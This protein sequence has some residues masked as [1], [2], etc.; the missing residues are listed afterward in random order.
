RISIPSCRKRICYDDLLDSGG[1]LY[2]SSNASHQVG[3]G[4]FV[5]NDKN[6]VL[7]VQEKHFAPALSGLWKIPTGFIH[8]FL[9]QTQSEVIFTGTVREVQEETGSDTEFV[10]VMA[11]R[12]VHDVAF[13]K[14]D[15]FFVCLLRPLS[16]QIMVDDLEIQD[17][18]WMPLAEFV[19]QPLIQ[20]DDMF[21]KL[22]DIFIATLGKRYCG[23]SVHQLVSKFDD[24]LSTLYFNTVDDPNLNCQ[25][26]RFFHSILYCQSIINVQDQINRDREHWKN[27][28]SRIISIIKT[29]GKNN[30]AFRGENEKTY[31]ENNGNFLSLI[32]MFA[33]FHPFMQEHIRRIKHDEIHNHYLGHNIQN[34]LINLLAIFLS[35]TSHQDQMSFIIRSLDISTTPINITEYFLEF[36]EVD[37]TSGKGFASAMILAKEIALEMNIEPEFRK[38]RVIY[39]KKQFDENVDNEITRSLE[40]SFRVDYFLYIVDQAIFSLQNRFEQFEVYENIFG[41]LFSGEKIE[42]IR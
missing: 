13:Q 21:K 39:R 7:V 6:E 30:L 12:H 5:I 38:K 41:F 24:K 34:E 26:N 31:Q 22:I 35:N 42:I 8:E 33:E 36:L 4:G 20:E 19:E 29:F 25:A 27:V 18:K 9:R 11:F 28:L 1:T 32:E 23:L 15:L 10:E 40:E 17:A 3:V 2:A 16:K 37:D 14:S